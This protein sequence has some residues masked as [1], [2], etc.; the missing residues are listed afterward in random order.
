MRKITATAALAALVLQAPLAQAAEASS[1]SKGAEAQAAAEAA[2]LA[3]R[4]EMKRLGSY[5]LRC[6]GEPNNTTG[7]E[8]FARLVGAVTLLA[9]FA[10]T[11]ESPDPAKRLFGE[12]GVAACSHLLDDPK[13]ETNKIR[14]IPLILA[15]SLHQVEA[16]NYTAALVDVDKARAEAQAAGLSGNPYFDRSVGMSFDQI[17]SVIRLRMDD[18]A[19]AEDVSLRSVAG[20]QYGIV[21]LLSAETYDEF[22]P[23]LSPAR[24]AQL[25][26]LVRLYPVALIS[27]AARLEE[28]GRFADAA[29]CRELVIEVIDGAKPELKSSLPYALA[30]LDHALAGDGGRAGT[31]EADAR[32]NIDSRI[33]AGKA[34]D[35]AAAVVEVLDLLGIVNQAGQG[36]LAEAR[37][38]FAARSQWLSPGFGTV[39]EANRRLRAG[40]APD[41]LFGALA[42]TPE[43][44]WAERR[45]KERI[46]RLAADSDNKTLFN[47]LF[48]YESVK[49]F[50]GTSKAVW[51]TD[52]SR[53][54]LKEPLKQSQHWAILSPGNG[55]AGLDGVVLHAALMAK[56]RAKK[57]FLMNLHLSRPLYGEVSFVDSGETGVSPE[58]YLDADAVIAALSPL[59]PSPETL[60]QRKAPPKS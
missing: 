3:E 28:V 23:S 51:R 36:K 59:I 60:A 29:R 6:D 7:A 48:S 46:R 20:Q 11:P 33:A 14:R 45:D 57:G 52:K 5:Y 10:P 24:E 53:L 44:L 16:K 50:E 55:L 49:D 18:P 21:Q 22:L 19:K 41:E 38:M 47:N 8:D 37:R 39:M 4:E 13:E 31:R 56:A 9:L 40:A 12:K 54:M 1:V 30:A 15:R 34:E 2:R 43:A 42:K 58:L 17:E 25:K 32:A 27:Y 35:N 26:A